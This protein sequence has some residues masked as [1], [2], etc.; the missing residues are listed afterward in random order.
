M[1]RKIRDR[2][3]DRQRNDMDVR[4]KEKKERK[5]ESGKIKRERE[6]EEG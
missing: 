4:K 5:T 3:M 1:G 2:K 6:G